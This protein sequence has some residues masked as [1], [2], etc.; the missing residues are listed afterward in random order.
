MTIA[1]EALAGELLAR[2]HELLAEWFPNGRRVGREW[3]VG[4]MEG[5]PGQSL[6]INLDSG[7]WADYATGQKGRDLIALY[8]AMRH[9][10]NGEAA[11]QL[12]GDRLD[13][14]A[15]ALRPAVSD[16]PEETQLPPPSIDL[17]AAQFRHP[18]HGVPVGVWVYRTASRAPIMVVARYQTPDGKTFLPWTWSGQ[19]WRMKAHAKPRPLYGLDRLETHTGHV[20][21]V[22]GEK[23][24]DALQGVT[25]LAAV[26]TWPGGAR[27]PQY[28]DWSP[29]RG[30]TC[31]LW[32]DVDAPGFEAMQVVAARL[33]ALGCELQMINTEGLPEGWDAADAVAEGLTGRKLNDW[34]KPRL[35]AVSRPQPAPSRAVA[36]PS[37]GTAT[38]DAHANGQDGPATYEVAGR[39]GLAFGKQGV[40]DNLSNV[41][42][43]I[44]GKIADKT[45]PA[46]FFD[47]FTQKTSIETEGGLLREWA[48]SDTLAMTAVLQRQFDMPKVRKM[49]VEDAIN[50]YAFEHR[51]NSAQEWLL[52]L[53]WDSTPRIETLFSRGFGAKAGPYL[54]AVG[55][56]FMVGIAAR[57]LDPGCQ[58]DTLPVLE[59]AQGIRKSS[60][61]RVLGG[62][63]HVECMESV[64]NKDFYLT[65]AGKLLVEIA[66]MR[67]FKT[68]DIERINGVITCRM[69]RY[70]APYERRAADHPRACVFAATTNV[71]DWNRDDT[72]ARRFLPIS[73]GVIDVPWIS[74]NRNQLFAEAAARWKRHE[75]WWDIPDGLARAEQER[76]RE[77]DAIARSLSPFLLKRNRVTVAECVDFCVGNDKAAR[78]DRGLQRRVASILRGWGYSDTSGVDEHG[79]AVRIWTLRPDLHVARELQFPEEPDEPA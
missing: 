30:R 61:L 41:R 29:L 24:A 14:R 3:C 62:P 32:P 75:A 31:I 57:V 4:D 45:W 39:Y 78:F 20:F 47:I 38:M 13:N 68:A 70:R 53:K 5:N 55:R 2:G 11:K 35:F 51:R 6:K 74:A 52:S 27:N 56:C 12:S 16:E 28:A 37:N 40:F 21:L 9:I 69:D 71:T 66:E 1:F 73:C 26:L 46:V 19:K 44:D 42:T 72:G 23:A 10:G 64:T 18:R 34:L 59:G 33:L 49:T 48:E 50:L 65:I 77:E 79:H 76:R 25:Q 17:N 67:S 43:L 54:D 7:L 60:A 22:E 63:Y 58:V 15:P 36:D 8:A